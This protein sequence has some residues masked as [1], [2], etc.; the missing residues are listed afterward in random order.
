MNER[1]RNIKYPDTENEPA[2]LSRKRLVM[3]FFAGPGESIVGKR[4]GR[5]GWTRVLVGV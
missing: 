2:K 5:T 3:L 1:R 4:F